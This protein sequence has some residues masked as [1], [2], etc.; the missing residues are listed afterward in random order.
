MDQPLILM[1]SVAS[2]K[3]R[4]SFQMAQ[5]ASL[6]LGLTMLDA[7][8][9]DDISPET[10]RMRSQNWGRPL[11]PAEVGCLLSHRMA[12]ELAAARHG[13]TLVLEDDA[14]LTDDA[15]SLIRSLAQRC[16]I[17]FVNLETYNRP[18]LLSRTREPLDGTRYALSRLYRD[19]G[20]AAAYMLWP[21]AARHLLAYTR[22]FSPLADSALTLAPGFSRHQTEPAAAIQAM[23]LK[24]H[25]QIIESSLA[26]SGKRPRQSYPP[27]WIRSKYLRASVS[28]RL[29]MN[30]LRHRLH[31]QE[32]LV[33][34][35]SRL[36]S[37][38]EIGQ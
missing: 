1:I 27:L 17:S 29:G 37:S 25:D 32:R 19:R 30:Q 22:T 5:F 18:K 10:M 4:R 13:S 2:Q 28:L 11:R 7:I 16:D 33:P 6:G 24:G 34:F 15:A 21:D 14:I 8:E 23:F 3:G 31:S 9:P 12:W 26:S 35:G 20:G 38:P 36:S